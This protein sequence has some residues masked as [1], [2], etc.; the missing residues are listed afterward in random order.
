LAPAL[1]VGVFDG[2]YTQPGDYFANRQQTFF[3]AQQ[4]SLLPVICVLTNTIVNIA[5][6]G[7]AQSG[8]YNG[9]VAGLTPDILYQWPAYVH[10]LRA[11]GNGKAQETR[12]GA[13]FILM[14]LLPCAPQVS[15]VISDSAGR[16]FATEAA[17]Q[18]EAGWRLLARQIAG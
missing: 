14:P 16:T 11:T 2:F 9:N 4:E 13:W 10:A 15:D 8:T 17:E 3:V 1:R 18:T 6:V 5:R 7:P 12:F